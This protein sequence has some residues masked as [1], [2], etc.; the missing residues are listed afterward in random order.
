MIEVQGIEKSFG[1]TRALDGVE[2]V[3]ETGRVLALLGPNGAGKTTLV[4]ILTTLLRPDAGW[5]RVAGLD[6]V[7]DAAALRSVIGLSGQFAAIDDLLTGRENLQMVG[8]LYHLTRR[9]AQNRA[10]VLLEQFTLDEAAD[11][12][13]KTYSGGMRR[14]LDLAASLIARP[15]VLVLDEPTTGLDPRT[16]IDM[17]NS[18][19]ELA[20]EGATVLLTTQYLEDAERLAHYL[21]VIDHGRVIAE[22]TT[23][24]LKD[25]L[26]GDVIELRV[27]DGVLIDDVVR[28]VES[29]GKGSMVV[30]RD[31]KRVTLPA[32]E[33]SLTL[34]TV[35]QCL[36]DAGLVVHD[37]GIR[38][39][40]LDDVFLSLTG[41]GAEDANGDNGP[42]TER[43]VRS[44]K[45][46]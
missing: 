18:I 21:V 8:E 26:G 31:R 40:S 10:K 13:A 44:R 42:S 22:G 23:D 5:A 4:R 35:L 1:S 2:F 43:L 36:D 14:R 16:R 45:S 28:A 46:R 24:Q 20:V 30:D 17:W 19:D 11:R 38:R 6:T 39:P 27:P 32:T 9:D 12:L 25:M 34:R 37:I 33:G 29:N 41:H 3:A 7:N 15:P